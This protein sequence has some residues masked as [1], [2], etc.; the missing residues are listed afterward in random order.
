MYQHFTVYCVD[1]NT[2]NSDIEALQAFENKLL[3]EL[4]TQ[5]ND[6]KL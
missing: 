4:K 6:R 2:I 5:I 1:I 3:N